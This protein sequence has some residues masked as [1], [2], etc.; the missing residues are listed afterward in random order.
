VNSD[1]DHEVFNIFEYSKAAHPPGRGTH[2]AFNAPTRKAVRQFWEAGVRNG[3]TDEVCF[4]PFMFLNYLPSFE[5][6][7]LD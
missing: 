4:T 3:G 7:I 2:V 6:L 5:S 1:E